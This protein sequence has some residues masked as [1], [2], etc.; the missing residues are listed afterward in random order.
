MG[1][2][3]P[4]RH[5]SMVKGDKG[6]RAHPFKLDPYGLWPRESTRQK[7]SNP[8]GDVNG[9]EHRQDS[10]SIR[11]SEAILAGCFVIRTGA[12]RFRN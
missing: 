1:Q 7:V 10:L 9:G 5:L 3:R 4:Y 8:A 12:V 11:D 2:A 6:F